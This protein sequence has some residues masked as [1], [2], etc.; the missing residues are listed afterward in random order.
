ML[1]TQSNIEEATMPN[2]QNITSKNENMKKEESYP[3]T[4]V[5]NDNHAEPCSFNSNRGDEM[6]DW[7]TMKAE[8]DNLLQTNCEASV[9][10]Q[11][12]RK[13]SDYWDKVRAKM[14]NR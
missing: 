10:L 14:R 4:K 11:K 9:L 13:V 2:K 12:G 8:I 5:S 6:Q 3:Q 1:I 7:Q